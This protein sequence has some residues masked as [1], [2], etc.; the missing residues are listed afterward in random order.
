M[1]ATLQ[2]PG[3][4]ACQI[5]TTG[6]RLKEQEQQNLKVRVVEL[7]PGQYAYLGINYK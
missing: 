2:S 1:Q 4:T 3:S 5:D 7:Y 6:E